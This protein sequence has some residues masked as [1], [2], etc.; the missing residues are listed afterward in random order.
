MKARILFAVILVAIAVAFFLMG[1]AWAGKQALSKTTTDNLATAMRGEAFA[2]AK[3]MLYAEHA[4]Q[5]GN[6]R[7]AKLF[8][9][10][11]RTERFEHFAEEARLAGL[12]GSDAENV[13]D[14]MQGE[15]YEVE[16]MYRE[17]KEKAEATGD[18]LAAHRFQ[19]IREDETKHR[20]AFK[21][22][23]AALTQTS[24]QAR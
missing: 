5:N 11:A 16:S 17:F 2:Y 7:L 21:S 1:S 4:R 19:E 13:R 20:D 3:Y 12:V 10:T 8:E 15:S 23:L 18:Q 24:S 6:E 9:E 22:E 14:A